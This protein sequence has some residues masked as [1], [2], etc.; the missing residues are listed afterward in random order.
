[1]MKLTKFWKDRNISK[2]T[3]V[4]R[5]AHAL[6]FPVVTYGFETWTLNAN[7]RRRIEAFEMFCWRPMLRIPWVARRTN[8]SIL[9]ELQIQTRDTLLSKI[10]RGIIKFFGHIIR[11]NGLEKLVMQGKM[12]GRRKIAQQ[13]HT[14]GRWIDRTLLI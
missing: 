4:R 6:V 8:E 11:Q 5:L 2:V 10:Q 9:E 13:I 1:M 7:S 12:D 3:N 14:S